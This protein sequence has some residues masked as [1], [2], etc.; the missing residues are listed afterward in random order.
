M[1][2]NQLRQ[3]IACNSEAEVAELQSCDCLINKLEAKCQ[4]SSVLAE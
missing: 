4:M 3:Q 2:T 1:E